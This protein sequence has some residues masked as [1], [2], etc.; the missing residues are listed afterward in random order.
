MKSFAELKPILFGV[1]GGLTT[2]LVVLAALFA[3]PLG[4]SSQE[5]ISADQT[6]EVTTPTS[7]EEIVVSE[8]ES[9]SPEV[10]QCS[11][12]ELE[13]NPL[14][15]DLQAQVIDAATGTVLFDRA[16]SAPAR[17]ASVMKLL[18]AAAALETLGPDYR[19]ITRV[20]A[21]AED[22][23]ILY[24]VG[25]GDVTLSRT[26][27]GTNSVYRNAP[28]LSDLVRQ[29][30]S[31]SSTQ[32]FSQIV[33]DSTLYGGP[34]GEYQ[35]VWDRR[36]LTEGYMSFVSAL[37]VDGDRDNPSSKDSA[38]SSDPVARA[39]EWFK[40]ELGQRASGA[41][42]SKGQAPANAVEIASVRSAP[43]PVLID[44]MLT[45]SDNSIAESLARLVSL[46]LG[47]D[48]SFASLTQ[49]FQV[50][51]RGTGIDLTGLKVEDGS[52]LSRFNQLSPASV[53]QLLQ[54]IDQKYKNFQVILDG[55]PVSGTPGSLSARF[56]DAVGKVIAKTGWIRTGYTL[57]GFLLP[58]DGSKLIFTVYNLGD[59]TLANQEAMDELVMG[60]YG[61][62][63]SLV[64]N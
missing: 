5:A 45:V 61:C 12:T 26:K 55:M 6:E 62:G 17:S 37:Q 53:N 14:V 35:D 27:P 25:G 19:I 11:V 33:L 38:R 9:V 7:S 54:K 51:L 40:Q 28:K 2:G 49:A 15:L 31:W 21:D 8:S 39:G 52:G 34:K 30:G 59:V 46:D 43:L 50:A 47:L 64:N 48:G 44:Y 32:T 58:E 4:G 13:E 18:T 29:I 3:G 57:S 56:E 41:F 16:S 1:A 42:L 36:G 60:F 23:S 22:P 24:F 10:V 20:Y 63:L